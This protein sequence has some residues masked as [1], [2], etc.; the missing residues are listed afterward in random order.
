VVGRWASGRWFVS[1]PERTTPSRDLRISGVLRRLSCLGDADLNASVSRVLSDL[2]GGA[3]IE[4]MTGLVRPTMIVMMPVALV[5]R[6]PSVGRVLASDEPLPGR[7]LRVAP[8][9]CNTLAEARQ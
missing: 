6:H 4:A 1:R 5:A 7:R 2:M 8:F 3:R 9:P